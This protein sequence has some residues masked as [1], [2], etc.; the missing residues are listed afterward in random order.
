MKVNMKVKV[1]VNIVMV[2]P[3]ALS[4]IGYLGVM[5]VLAFQAR[6]TFERNHLI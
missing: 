5:P 6:S 4:S 1:K 2:V 3:K